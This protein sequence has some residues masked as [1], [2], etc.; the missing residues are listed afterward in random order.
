MWLRPPMVGYPR[1]PIG[2]VLPIL[3]ILGLFVDIIPKWFGL[4]LHRSDVVEL[5]APLILP[6][7]P[8]F[9]TGISSSVITS[10]NF[11]YYYSSSHDSSPPG[12]FVGERPFPGEN[13][14]DLRSTHLV[15]GCGGSTLT[16]QT[17]AV[18]TSAVPPQT[19]AVPQ[20]SAIPPKTSAPVPTSPKTSSS[21]QGQITAT[22][23]NG[24]PTVIVCF[25]F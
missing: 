14:F 7:V 21:P 24:F 9:Q 15:T 11:F 12:N 4:E 23:A 6:S 19:S 13:F 25:Y 20:T 5:V 16:A 10:N 2:T 3:A 17:S 8:A 22:S 18:R 1:S